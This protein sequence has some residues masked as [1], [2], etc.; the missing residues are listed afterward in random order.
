MPYTTVRFSV[1][2]LLMSENSN[3]HLFHDLQ[4][5]QQAFAGQLLRGVV[6]LVLLLHGY[7][8]LQQI[9]HPWS[10]KLLAHFYGGYC[11]PI[12]KEKA[13]RRREVMGILPCTLLG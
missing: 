1:V 8:L 6:G 11:F 9:L 3:N 10:S 12:T 7:L 5:Q 4:A 2:A 13:A